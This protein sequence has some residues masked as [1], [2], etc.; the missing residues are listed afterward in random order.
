M[1]DLEMYNVSFNESVKFPLN[2]RE[3]MV[4]LCAVLLFSYLFTSRSSETDKN[5]KDLLQRIDEM[6]QR[7][8]AIEEGLLVVIGA[9]NTSIN[10]ISLLEDSIRHLSTS[11]ERTTDIYGNLITICNDINKKLRINGVVLRRTA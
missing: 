2:T 7:N 9:S 1:Q 3:A 5:Q 6:N 11:H 4:L 10:S 8:R